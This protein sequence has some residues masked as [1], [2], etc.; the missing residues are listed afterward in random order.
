MPVYWLI[1]GT[2]AVW[3]ATH[4]V[5]AEAG[6]WEALS[7][8]RR[9]A[10]NGFLGKLLGCFYCSS[11]WIAAPVAALIGEGWQE[12]ALL[13]LA[14]SGGAILLERATTRDTQTPPATYFEDPEDDDGVRVRKP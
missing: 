11:L 12:R 3:R 8:L 10:G 1:V 4:L 9:A 7:R 13:W 6:P 14:V 5:S 2:L